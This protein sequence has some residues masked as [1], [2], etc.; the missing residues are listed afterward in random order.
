MEQ[1]VIEPERV[2]P[3]IVEPL[4]VEP[5]L[6]EKAAEKLANARRIECFKIIT[7]LV[8]DRMVQRMR[9]QAAIQR[10][11]KKCRQF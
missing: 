1:K 6:D 4:N 7:S 9:A 10:W 11:N 8:G 5:L 3:E 2:E